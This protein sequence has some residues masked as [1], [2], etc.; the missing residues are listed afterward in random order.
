[1]VIYGQKYIIRFELHQAPESPSA[2]GSLLL[3]PPGTA[4]PA[5]P[6]AGDRVPEPEAVHEVSLPL[7]LLS[8]VRLDPSRRSLVSSSRE[9]AVGWAGPPQE[10]WLR[11]RRRLGAALG[12]ARLEPE[13]EPLD[14]A[15]GREIGRRG[16]GS[17]EG[18]EERLLVEADP[19]PVREEQG[20]GEVE[21]WP[22]IYNPQR[23][24]RALS[25]LF[26]SVRFGSVRLNGSCP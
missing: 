25:C 10:E 18:R 24:L 14:S 5:P 16:R 17:R 11:G 3:L 23:Y 4:P 15:G 8:P 22:Q 21:P 6:L 7:E 13:E 2:P 19:F 26:R 20:E 12:E 1:M 9:P